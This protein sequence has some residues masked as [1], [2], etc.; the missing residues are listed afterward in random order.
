MA[1][2]TNNLHSV[3][4]MKDSKLLSLWSGVTN[5]MEEEVQMMAIQPMGH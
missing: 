2:M 4:G 5:S 3:D 1:I